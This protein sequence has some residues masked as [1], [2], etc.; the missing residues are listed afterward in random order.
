MKNI[1]AAAMLLSAASASA[2]TSSKATPYTGSPAT[3]TMARIASP[4]VSPDGK[5]IVYFDSVKG[6]IV[7]NADG[8]GAKSIAK[9]GI[10]PAWATNSVIVYVVS[11]DD[12]YQT[13]TASLMAHDIQDGFT[14]TAT[15]NDLIVD[16]VC[17][18]GDGNVVFTTTDGKAFSITVK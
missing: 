12:G 18:A 10:F 16:A 6:V 8:S 13:T 4:A 15:D 3:P 11:H 17:S 7:A 14:I 2:L 1:L 9:E 5:H